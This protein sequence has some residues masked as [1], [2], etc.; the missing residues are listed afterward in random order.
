MM[1]RDDIQNNF[2]II[3]KPNSYTS[4]IACKEKFSLFRYNNKESKWYEVLS[5]VYRYFPRMW[6]SVWMKSVS[7]DIVHVKWLSHWWSRLEW[8]DILD[9]YYSMNGDTNSQFLSFIVYLDRF[10]RR[11]IWICFL[12][13]DLLFDFAVMYE[14]DEIKYRL[15]DNRWSIFTLYWYFYRSYSI[16]IYTSFNH[17][18]SCQ[19]NTNSWY[20][21]SFW[22]WRIIDW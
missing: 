21:N 2:F 13:D 4:F 3:I 18:F 19:L 1:N 14:T 16:R 17:I 5:V 11:F 12:R 8:N 7:I 10:C 22:M 20:S 6:I 9:K 15:N